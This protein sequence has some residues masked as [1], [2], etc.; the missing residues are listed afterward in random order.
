MSYPSLEQYQ[1]ALQHPRTALLDPALK[2]GTVSTSGLGL[3]M[4]MCGGFA[5]TYTVSTKAGKYAVRCF[6]KQ[7]PD[8]EGRYRAISATLSRLTSSYFL[9]FEFQPQG[10]RI[11]GNTYPIVKMA[12]AIGDTLG[13]FV[14]DNRANKS[15]LTALRQNLTALAAYLESQQIAHGD[16]QPGNLMIGA[17]GSS[18]QL[19]DYDGMFVPAIQSLG[20][21]ESGHRNFQHPKRGVQ[22]SAQ[23]DRFS[24]ICLDVA[25][26]AIE[27]DATL[28]DKTQSD[29]DSFLFRTSDFGDPG[30]SAIFQMLM[31]NPSLAAQAK[32]FASICISNFDSTPSLGDFLASRGIPQAQ[33][34]VRT[35]PI[36]PARYTSQY[37]V[38]DAENY[39]RFLS[40]VGSVVELIG[41]VTDVKRGFS[42]R[43]RGPYVFV[44]FGD[45][46]GNIVKLTVWSAAL[47]KV[48]DQINSSLTG[49]WVSVVGL[50]EPPYVSRKFNY[51]H[52]SIDIAGPSQVRKIS[53][54]EAMFRLGR[55]TAISEAPASEINV[56]IKEKLGLSPSRPKKPGRVASPRPMSPP[57]TS[58]SAILDR[59]RQK[60]SS[61]SQLQTTSTP[62]ASA[63]STARP[64][65]WW[66]KIPWWIWV[67]GAVVLCELLLR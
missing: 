29:A 27:S 15:A 44:N 41:K 31:G 37:S 8:L 33:I 53:E 32:A 13:D 61:P 12:W 36:P 20:A 49:C 10:V 56:S 23:L 48:K 34:N 55:G 9:P 16:V 24:F 47:P 45:W 4:V 64:T 59:M 58:N 40:H 39:T 25:L 28:W 26:K 65:K 38:L 5:L 6:H 35:A 3:P 2:V 19:I 52:L 51:S 18:A 54:S 1:E 14:S 46:R 22:F 7:S 30:S 42:S 57:R 50:V 60:Q 43:G 11:A 66:K 21:S 17:R 63:S 67:S 62:Q